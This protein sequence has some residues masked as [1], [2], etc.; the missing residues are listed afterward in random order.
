MS[1]TN[2]NRTLDQQLIGYDVLEWTQ[3]ER[4][5]RIARARI[6]LA[7]ECGWL[8]EWVGPHPNLGWEV[9]AAGGNVLG[10]RSEDGGVPDDPFPIDRTRSIVPFVGVDPAGNVIEV[11]TGG[12]LLDDSD[13]EI[14]PPNDGTWRTLIGRYR[15]TRREPGKLTLVGGSTTVVGTGTEFTRYSDSTSPE[16]TILRI[17]ASETSNGNEGS[18]VI[19]VIT[20]DENMTVLS[21][22]PTT[23]TDV[24]FRVK[25]QFFSGE[26]ASPD[27][28]RNATVRW[29]LVTRT[30][31]RPTDGLIAYDVKQAG[32]VVSLIDRRRGSLYQ[33]YTGRSCSFALLPAYTWWNNTTSTYTIVTDSIV[34]AT[35]GGAAAPWHQTLSCVESTPLISRMTPSVTSAATCR[36][37]IRAQRISPNMPASVVPMLSAT[38]I[39]PC[40][41]A[42]MA[43][44]VDVGEAQLSGVARSSRAG[45]NRS[46]NA[47]PT[48]RGWPLRMG[49]VPRIQTLRSPFFKR[50]VVRVAVVTASRVLT[51]CGSR[52]RVSDMRSFHGGFAAFGQRHMKAGSR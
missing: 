5:Q 44:R 17:D 29:E 30:T 49:L 3:A 40:G 10:T 26:P 47:L 8:G 23:E 15:L 24:F 18:Y 22:P 39:T 14:V 31:T 21:A 46:V 11:P 45:T 13:A 50:M 41:I 7:H 36:L 19:D 51:T 20:D 42:S 9:F 2:G 28:H 32:G 43:A 1:D 27:I 35:G 38:A 12:A 52:G 33:P 25:G 16:P 4:L 37:T 34:A 6:G 48:L